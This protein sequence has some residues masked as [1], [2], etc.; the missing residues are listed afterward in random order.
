MEAK[1]TD[2]DAFFDANPQIASDSYS[3][4]DA[5]HY[6]DGALPASPDKESTEC[7]IVYSH[8]NGPYSVMRATQMTDVTVDLVRGGKY[9]GSIIHHMN[10]GDLLNLLSNVD[11][12]NYDGYRC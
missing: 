11:G 4:V 6:F 7:G 5:S 8:D 3:I 10:T 9:K 12:A 1:V 2:T